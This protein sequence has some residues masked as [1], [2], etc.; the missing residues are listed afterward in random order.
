[1]LVLKGFQGA[2]SLGN[3]YWLCSYLSYSSESSSFVND[4]PRYSAVKIAAAIT[5]HARVFMHPYITRSDCFDTDTDSVVLHEKLPDDVISSTELGKL[6]L[7]YHALEGIF[8]APKSY[9]LGLKDNG[10]SV[11]VHKVAAKQHVTRDW[12]MNQYKNSNSGHN[13]FITNPFTV[14]LR[15]LSI[16]EKTLSYTLTMPE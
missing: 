3:G 2:H 6:K 16:R 4:P 7:E 11:L 12:Y 14:D 8:L 15:S 13:V 9:W 5:A 10:N 1:M